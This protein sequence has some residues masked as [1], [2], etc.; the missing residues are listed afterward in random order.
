VTYFILSEAIWLGLGL[1]DRESCIETPA[2]TADCSRLLR[3]A[4]ATWFIASKS[5]A[6]VFSR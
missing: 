1:Q 5:D 3:T 4:N 2:M 6:T